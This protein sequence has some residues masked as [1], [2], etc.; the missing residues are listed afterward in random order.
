MKTKLLLAALFATTLSGSVLA[1]QDRFEVVIMMDGE[2]HDPFTTAKPQYQIRQAT[3]SPVWGKRMKKGSKKTSKPTSVILT[4]NNKQ[5][6]SGI[7]DSVYQTED[8]MKADIG[9]FMTHYRLQSLPKEYEG[10]FYLHQSYVFDPKTRVFSDTTGRPCEALMFEGVWEKVALR[11]PA[12]ITYTIE[13]GDIVATDTCLRS[14][15]GRSVNIHDASRIVASIERDMITH[16]GVLSNPNDYLSDVDVLRLCPVDSTDATKL[17]FSS[18]FDEYW[19]DTK[20]SGYFLDPSDLRGRMRI[21]HNNAPDAASE[22]RVLY[23]IDSLREIEIGSVEGLTYCRDRASVPI[24]GIRTYYYGGRMYAEV[25]ENQL[26]RSKKR[27]N[28]ETILFKV[29][30]IVST[31]MVKIP[32]PGTL[33][34]NSS[35]VCL[36]LLDDL[37]AYVD[38]RLTVRF[39]DGARFLVDGFVFEEV[40]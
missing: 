30:P 10:S 9:G 2:S 32:I 22:T 33:P 35:E 25:G 1:Q 12:E 31:H 14:A 21:E 16:L 38:G 20:Q 23:R 4:V 15:L 17:L 6:W 27:G 8:R 29:Y 24:D 28:E 3:V 11:H 39:Q 40:K 18:R 19:G 34:Y 13:A 7:T 5:L 26:S 37:Y 36:E